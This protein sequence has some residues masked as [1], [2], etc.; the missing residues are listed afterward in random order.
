MY[1]N[2][3]AKRRIKPLRVSLSHR[4]SAVCELGGGMTCLA[5]LMIAVCA[6]VKEVLLSDGNEKAIQSILALR[7]GVVDDAAIIL[8]S[9][10]VVRWDN[11]ADM[12]ALEDRFDVVMC[13]DC[14]F[15][16]QYR[17]SLVDALRR[18]LRPDGTALVFAPTRGDT[19][20]EFCRLAESAGLRV[21]RYDNYDSH[22]WDLHLKGL[23][24]ANIFEFKEIILI[25]T[26]IH[27]N[28]IN[29]YRIGLNKRRP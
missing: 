2:V 19:L 29:M 8:S 13:A 27:R 23:T 3:N 7:T 11:E 24:G 6:D 22:L 20:A 28:S 5:G 21:C 25:R 10:R 14:L 12:S 15:L 26:K 16:D 9:F 18:L 17:G 1:V 4:G